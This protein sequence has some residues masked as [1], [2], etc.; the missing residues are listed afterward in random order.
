M[1]STKGHFPYPGPNPMGNEMNAEAERD[2]RERVEETQR[3]TAMDR[4][5]VPWWRRLRRRASA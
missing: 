5:K 1:S 4:R 2:L 3:T